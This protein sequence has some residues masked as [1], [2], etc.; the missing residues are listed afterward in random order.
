MPDVY[1]M[2]NIVSFGTMGNGLCGDWGKRE[3]GLVGPRVLRRSAALGLF[4]CQESWKG[5]SK[6]ENEEKLVYMG[7]KC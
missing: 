2:H 4:K 5:G 7:Y 3:R 1:K 6:W